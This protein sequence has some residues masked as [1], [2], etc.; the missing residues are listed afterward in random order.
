M[1]SGEDV[2]DDMIEENIRLQGE[3]PQNDEKFKV[4]E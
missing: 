3:E 2:T 1:C 4:T